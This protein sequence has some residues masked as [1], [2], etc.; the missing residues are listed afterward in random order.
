MSFFLAS[1]LC[2]FHSFLQYRIWTQTFSLAMKALYAWAILPFLST[3]ALLFLQRPAWTVN[4][5]QAGMTGTCHPIQLFSSEMGVSLAF[6]ARLAWNCN[7]PNL[8]WPYSLGSCHHAQPAIGWDGVLLTFCPGWP[9]TVILLI[10]VSQ[11]D[12]IAAVSHQCLAYNFF[13]VRML[14]THSAVTRW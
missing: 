1:F 12:G 10:S 6:W 11:V 13:M 2:F 8:S 3:L 7:P 9:P 5:F 4:L 14:F